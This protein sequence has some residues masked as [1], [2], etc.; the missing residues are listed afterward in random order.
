MRN[1][2]EAKS[3]VSERIVRGLKFRRMNSESAKS[4]R[5]EVRSTVQFQRIQS[6][7]DRIQ[8]QKVQTLFQ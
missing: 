7:V 6:P 3:V 4:N 1:Q 8:N 2:V 5:I